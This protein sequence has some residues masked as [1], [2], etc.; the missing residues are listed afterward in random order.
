MREMRIFTIAIFIFFCSGLMPDALAYVA[1]T[2]IVPA[3][4]FEVAIK[5]EFMR[6]LA[7][8]ENLP[9]T[10]QKQ[11]PSV[12]IYEVS[13]GYSLGTHSMFQDLKIR[14]MGSY[15]ASAVELLNGS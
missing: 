9:E 15:F 5:T 12:E 10:Q 7:G 11:T 3:G 13:G 14:L 6:G 1:G 2:S 8:P 4:G